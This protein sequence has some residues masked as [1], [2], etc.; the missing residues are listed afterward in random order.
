MGFTKKTWKNRIAEY[1]NR[2]RITMEDGSTSLVTVARYEGTIS[3]EGDAFNAANMNDLEDRIEAEFNE[4]TQSL[5]N[6]YVKYKCLLSES[7][8]KNVKV[9][10]LSKYKIL[11]LGMI[12]RA[13]EQ[14]VCEFSIPCVL[15]SLKTNHQLQI[16]VN[17]IPKYCNIEYVDDNTI[18][19]N[20]DSGFYAV[21][22]GL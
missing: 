13:T 12:H 7:G 11:H 16:T 2:R 22:Y 4:V 21:V 8:N 3:Q 6:F 1:I 15:F 19:I 14:A 17:G 18:K 5:A 9:E 20:C 10:S